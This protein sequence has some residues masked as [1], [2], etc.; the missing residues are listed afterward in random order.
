MPLTF[1]ILSNRIVDSKSIHCLL[2]LAR[3]VDGRKLTPM[4][5]FKR[6]TLPKGEI[7]SVFII[8]IQEKD[9]LDET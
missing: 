7:P 6:I 9:W 2:V 4:V 8:Q 5:I 1:D 3:Y